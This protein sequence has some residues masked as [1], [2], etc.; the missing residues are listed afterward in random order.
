MNVGSF[1]TGISWEYYEQDVD[2]SNNPL[3]VTAK[4]QTMKEEILNYDHITIYQY[5]KEIP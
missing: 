4:Y 2:Q 5:K 3:F 1:S